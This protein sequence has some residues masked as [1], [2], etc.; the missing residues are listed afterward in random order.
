MVLLLHQ[1]LRCVELLLL[2][3]LL[4]EE[5]RQALVLLGGREAS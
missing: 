1:V 3:E 4:A 5:R 2:E